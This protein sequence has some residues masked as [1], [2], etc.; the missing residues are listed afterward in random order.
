MQ[1]KNSRKN[2]DEKQRGLLF[3]TKKIRLKHYLFKMH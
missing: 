1:K 2:F 3:V